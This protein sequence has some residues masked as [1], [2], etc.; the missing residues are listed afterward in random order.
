MESMNWDLSV[1]WYTDAG[2]IFAAGVF[3]KDIDKP[4]FIRITEIEDGEFEG[5]NTPSWKSS[6]RRMRR[7]ATSS[8]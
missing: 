8:A 3:Y 7:R 6:R 2:G 4:I 5:R 1:E